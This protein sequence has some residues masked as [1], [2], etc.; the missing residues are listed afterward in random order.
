[1]RSTFIVPKSKAAAANAQAAAMFG[2]RAANMFSTPVAK[3]K[4]DTETHYAACVEV[5]RGRSDELIKKIGLA[6]VESQRGA[7]KKMA[8]IGYEHVAKDVKGV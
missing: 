4:A 1:M 3:G 5:S 2:P 8:D 6:N 7:G